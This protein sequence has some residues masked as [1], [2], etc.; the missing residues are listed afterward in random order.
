MPRTTTI[1]N[2]SF[3]FVFV[4][5]ERR[6]VRVL[7]DYTPQND[8]ELELA[9]GDVIEFLEEVCTRFDKIFYLDILSRKAYVPGSLKAYKLLVRWNAQYLYLDSSYTAPRS[10]LHSI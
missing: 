9:L 5:A 6:K 4:S 7:Y 2:W 3:Y 1:V 8:D 10:Q